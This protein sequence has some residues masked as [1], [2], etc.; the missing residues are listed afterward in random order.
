MSDGDR[1]DSGKL[2]AF[3][4]GV[5]VG[6]LLSLGVGTAFFMVQARQ[7]VRATQEAL[8]EATMAREEAE[9]ARQVAERE[10]QRAQEALQA[11]KKAKE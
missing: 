10:R 8:I 9:A 1:E 5:L 2:G 11:V 6:I 3:L 4:L 7:G